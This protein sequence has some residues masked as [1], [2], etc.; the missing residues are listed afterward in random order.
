M[1]VRISTAKVSPSALSS[2][3]H[4][5]IAS[6][7]EQ[8]R[9]RDPYRSGRQPPSGATELR[10]MNETNEFIQQV[11]G[12]GTDSSL[13]MLKSTSEMEPAQPPVLTD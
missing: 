1:P 5:R 12:K 10:S 9:S 8:D 4:M 6:L 13:S 3:S 2:A 11:L 7:E